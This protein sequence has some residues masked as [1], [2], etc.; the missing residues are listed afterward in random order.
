MHPK[1]SRT[2]PPWRR[3]LTRLQPRS[4][5]RATL[6]LSLAV[7]MAMAAAL[8]SA[9]QHADHTRARLES[10]AEQ[11]ES[12]TDGMLATADQRTAIAWGYAE[13]LR[14]GLESPFRLIESAASDPRLTTDER[15]TVSWALLARVLRGE[16]HEVEPAALDLIGPVENGAIAAGEQHL[17]LITSA[18][19]GAKNPRAAELAVRFAYTLASTERIIDGAGPLLAAEAAAM[20]ADREIGRREAATIVRA[21]GTSDAIDVLR[22]KR[23]ARTF[24][25]ERPVLLA[26]GRDLEQEA[27]SQ[28]AWLLDSLRAMHPVPIVATEE[29]GDRE[30]HSGGIAPQLYA[31]GRLAV[32]AAPLAV[33]VQRY[34]PILRSYAPAVD[35][36]ALAAASNAE[37]LVAA[38]QVPDAGRAQRRAIGRLLLAASVAMRSLSQD[39]IT[40]AVD[41]LPAVLAVASALGVASITFDRDVPAAWRPHLT[42]SLETGVRDLRRV[43]PTLSLGAVRVRFR[44]SAPADSALAMHDPRTRTLHLPAMTAG[45]TLLHELAHE[46][47]RQSA[48][49][50]G[51]AGYRSD[52]V[53]RGTGVNS[54]RIASP[55]GRVAASLRAITEESADQPRTARVGTDRPAEIFATRVDWFV[56]QALAREGIS[57]GFLTG[58]QDELLTGHVVHPERLRTASRAR[59][60]LDAL[61]GMTTVAAFARADEEPSMQTLLR[62]ALGASLDR[63]VAASIVR[64]EAGFWMPSAL[65][66]SGACATDES[67]RVQLIRMAAESRVRGWLRQRARWIPEAER[68]G[69]AR[70]VLRQSPWTSTLAAHR[71]SELRDYLLVQLASSGELPAGL[72]AYAAPLA[73]RARCN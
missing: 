70:A 73:I 8:G 27:A 65:V 21:A 31:A 39:P 35:A 23:A 69:W 24:Y 52:V 29:A 47:D 1:M 16:T 18:I 46:L 28:S 32:P 45:G 64:G 7:A 51:L 67:G 54:K 4:V 2:I 68:P 9:K 57:N 44:M 36:N 37:M 71:V 13:R 11:F 48:L 62:W 43:L 72:G 40:V 30:S 12:L 22:R 19:V 53:A 25:L 15:Y 34:R 55:G 60:L 20:I 5:R 61:E 6:A 3:A 14:L 66:G 56:A 38:T 33:T 59:S 42:R 58:V 50:Q 10:A 26:P 17:A 63:G 41:S 49:Q